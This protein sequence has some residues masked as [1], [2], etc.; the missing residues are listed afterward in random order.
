MTPPM[1]FN[2]SPTPRPDTTASGGPLLHSVQTPSNAPEVV[3][4]GTPTQAPSTEC[5][6]TTKWSNWLNR[7]RPSTGSG[8]K[9]VALCYNVYV[10]YCNFYGC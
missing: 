4:T 2:Q 10:I 3:T 8:D 5:P 6:K 9:E 7:D 1:G